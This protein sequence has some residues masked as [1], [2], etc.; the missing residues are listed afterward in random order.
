MGLSPDSGGAA[1]N[2]G[3]SAAASSLHPDLSAAWILNGRNC[4]C[5]ASRRY[6]PGRSY[7]PGAAGGG[8][9]GGGAAGGENFGGENVGGENVGGK[10]VGG[11]NVAGENVAGP[12]AAADGKAA[13]SGSACPAS[14]AAP[15]PMAGY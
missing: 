9:A 11:K 3:P 13:F 6:T 7:I 1:S 15:S 14:Y 8:A 10:S 4:T 12:E 5:H 2:P